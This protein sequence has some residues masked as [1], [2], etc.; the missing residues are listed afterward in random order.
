MKDFSGIENITGYLAQAEMETQKLALSWE[1]T[2]ASSITS[3]GNIESMD[4]DCK[5]TNCTSFEG[6]HFSKQCNTAME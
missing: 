4:K 6:G 5:W 2:S 1:N 3:Q